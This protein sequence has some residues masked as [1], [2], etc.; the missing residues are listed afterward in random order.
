MVE[1][2]RETRALEQS[3]RKLPSRERQALVGGAF[4]FGPAVLRIVTPS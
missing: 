3:E 1:R 2:Y 4:A